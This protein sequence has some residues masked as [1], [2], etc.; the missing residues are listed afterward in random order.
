[1]DIIQNETHHTAE[2][3]AISDQKTKQIDNQKIA[4]V[5]VFP[6]LTEEEKVSGRIRI[7]GLLLQI[8]EEDI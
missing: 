7:T 1:M 6:S 3:S 8:I 2:P 4:V 5:S